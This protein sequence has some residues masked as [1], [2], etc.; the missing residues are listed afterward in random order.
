MKS[1]CY[2]M[3]RSTILLDHIPI[4]VMLAC[5]LCIHNVAQADA[6][7]STH[8]SYEGFAEPIHDIEISTDEVG[9]LTDVPVQLGQRVKAN[10]V[11][12]QLDDRVQHAAVEV[13]RSQAVMD[14]E[15]LAAEAT[16]ALQ[17]YRLEQIQKLRITNM[18]GVEELRRA[19]MD[20][21]VAAARVQMAK[22]QKTLRQSELTRLELQVE[23]RK[24]RAPFDGV[25]AFKKLSTGSSVTPVNATIMRLIRTDILVGVFN[26][27]AEPSFAMKPGMATQVYFRAARLT[28]DGQIESI[29][30][31]INGESGTVVVRVTIPNPNNQLMP[32]DRLSMRLTPGQ[33]SM[34]NSQ[35]SSPRSSKR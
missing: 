3:K 11:V 32:G 20:L 33:D 25:V 5:L 21:D 18:A 30:P 17:E 26:V 1:F 35:A 27:P 16:R 29:A 13:S 9:R 10:D 12:A 24:I 28:V 8:S 2:V 7:A 4:L 22:E 6:D 19:Q 15:I 14:G 34:P 23:Q 31:L